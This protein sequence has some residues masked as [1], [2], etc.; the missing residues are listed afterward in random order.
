MEQPLL[1]NKGGKKGL[2]VV[3]LEN[4]DTASYEVS[5]DG[6]NAEVMLFK[7]TSTG[8]TGVGGGDGA[9]CTLQGKQVVPQVT[10]ALT[11]T[12]SVVLNAAGTG[13][14]YTITP[15]QALG[16]GATIHFHGPADYGE[17][18]DPLGN[19]GQ[20][21]VLT[22]G[23]PGTFTFPADK[24]QEYADMFRLGKVYVNVHT[25]KEPNGEVRCQMD[26]VHHL[27]PAK[28]MKGKWTGMTPAEMHALRSGIVYL[29]VYVHT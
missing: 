1:D 16:A 25:D 23:A 20:P 12:A 13:V 5:V 8:A 7:G 21:E 9:T 14:S 3:T 29:Y 10:T 18:A 6:V 22:A 15:S 17:S 24:A 27:V 11:G 28:T 19:N 2:V 26:F 4:A